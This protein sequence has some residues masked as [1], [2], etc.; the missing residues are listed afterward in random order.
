MFAMWQKR[1]PQVSKLTALNHGP[2][3][4]FDYHKNIGHLNI[5]FLVIKN[6]SAGLMIY[7]LVSVKSGFV[8]YVQTSLRVFF[9]VR[10]L[11]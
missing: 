4:I 9:K 6:T 1:T 11:A 10:V 3:P 8:C 5:S 2:K 7:R